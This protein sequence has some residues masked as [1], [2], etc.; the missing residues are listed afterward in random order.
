MCP[1]IRLLVCGVFA[2]FVLPTSLLSQ[3]GWTGDLVGDPDDCIAMDEVMQVLAEWDEAAS[4]SLDVD[5]DGVATCTDLIAVLNGLGACDLSGFPD[6]ECNVVGAL[7]YSPEATSDNACLFIGALP[8][9]SA[10]TL[11][12]SDCPETGPCAGACAVNYNGVV[13][14]TGVIGDQCWFVDNLRTTAFADGALIPTADETGVVWHTA[15]VPLQCAYGNVASNG[16]IQGLLYNGYAVL[17][18]RGLCPS[19]WHVPTDAEFMELE[20]HLG[21]STAALTVT[22]WRSGGQGKAMKASPAD[23]P[24]WN[25]T[26]ASGLTVVPGGLR[27]GVSSSFLQGGVSAYLFS[28]TLDA[29]NRLLS[30]YLYVLS[31]GVYR[32][33]AR[34]TSGYSVRCI[35]D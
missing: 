16:E 18:S 10:C 12:E 21:M 1:V 26:N 5:A 19:G 25:G 28:S 34:L 14:P 32:G 31:E 30:R 20:A 6:G 8:E 7:N 23:E 29:E 9:A 24:G 3:T 33:P 22:G 35:R 11:P 17:D 2:C 27:S 13:Y 15:T 4:E